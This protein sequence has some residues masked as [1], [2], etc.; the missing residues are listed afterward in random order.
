M[1]KLFIATIVYFLS[2]NTAWGS[3]KKAEIKKS[4]RIS[5]QT[6]Q[7][8]SLDSSTL[9]RGSLAFYEGE[10]VQVESDTTIGNNRT[11]L[12][13]QVGRRFCGQTILKKMTLLSQKQ[14]KQD[15]LVVWSEMTDFGALLTIAG[16]ATLA[17]VGILGKML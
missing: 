12:L 4:V 1:H 16:T 6:A 11:L 2:I 17:V 14:G 13:S 10:Q 3:E 7:L 9:A 8:D 5:Q 15:E